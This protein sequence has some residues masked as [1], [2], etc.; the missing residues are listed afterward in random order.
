MGF[1]KIRH[2]FLGVA[3]INKDYNILGSMLG[4]PYFG[5]L[6]NTSNRAWDIIL[7]DFYSSKSAFV[8]LGAYV[9][10]ILMLLQK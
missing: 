6:R 2:T 3:I 7:Y 9:V 5:K 4:S 8:A 10:P 1:P